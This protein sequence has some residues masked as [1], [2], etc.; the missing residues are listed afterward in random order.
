[1][2]RRL[3]SL[4]VLPLLL[5]ACGSHQSAANVP[6]ASGHRDVV[7]RVTE[8]GGMGTEQMFFT[9]PPVLVVTGDGTTYVRMEE[10]TT[11]GIVWPLISYRVPESEL[12]MLLH[13]ADHDGLLAAPPDY[14][15]PDPISDA[16]DT[17][18]ALTAD[19]DTW[20]HRT[21]GLGDFDKE[22]TARAR[23]ADFVTYL[24]HWRLTPRKPRPREIQPQVL[25]VMAHPLP[26]GS[27][28]PDGRVGRWPTDAKVDLA[29]VGDCTVVRDPAV[30]RLLTTGQA[31]AYR[32]A[33][34]RYLVAAAV[35][36][37]GD[38]CGSGTGS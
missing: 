5:G 4:S 21:N 28:P 12:Q 9:E 30:V 15:P 19:G 14:T 33:G 22:T 38:S 27:A 25:R 3:V 18:V 26:D 23:L 2:R 32:Q 8:G 20:T 7:L 24:Q 6:H 10:A 31:H 1:M 13:E 11:Q 36:L 16:G 29:D 35:S 37:P 34:R 17:T